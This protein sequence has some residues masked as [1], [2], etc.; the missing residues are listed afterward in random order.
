MVS[1]VSSNSFTL[2]LYNYLRLYLHQ[3]NQCFPRRM[4]GYRP[5]GVQRWGRHLICPEE[6][7]VWWKNTDGLCN[8]EFGRPLFPFPGMYPLNCWDFLSSQ[9]CLFIH[10]SPDGL[11]KQDHRWW[12]QRKLV[13]KWWLRMEPAMPQKKL[14]NEINFMAS[15]ST[16]HVY[17]RKTQ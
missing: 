5:R 14:Q 16:N 7:E 15:D 1:K 13:I 12:T 4:L 17:V 8:K 9:K 10:D 3:F 11:C 2:K 6:L